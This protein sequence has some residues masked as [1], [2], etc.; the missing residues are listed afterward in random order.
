MRNTSLAWQSLDHTHTGQRCKSL[1]TDHS[2]P[3]LCLV[4]KHLL[5]FS[6]LQSFSSLHLLLFHW[7]SLSGAFVW[8]F[9]YTVQS[10]LEVKRCLQR[11]VCSSAGWA[12]TSSTG[13]NSQSVL[14]L[15]G[16]PGNL[17]VLTN[18]KEINCITLW[19]PAEMVHFGGFYTRNKNCYPQPAVGAPALP[20]L[21]PGF[22]QGTRAWSGWQRVASG[23]VPTA[24]PQHL[25][26]SFPSP[27]RWASNSSWCFGRKSLLDFF[28]VLE[29]TS[30]PDGR[31]L[32]QGS[33]S[34]SFS[35][36]S[37]VQAWHKVRES[38][39]W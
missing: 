17:S 1:P 24:G 31:C 35:P 26:S 10:L 23:T 7:Y 18:I 16:K 11:T 6:L 14:G 12:A 22:S 21:L 25:A 8:Y 32:V 28:L 30:A 34:A 15:C 19:F 2:W 39:S 4:K 9:L 33:L 37:G 36:P 5:L 38:P 27:P 20:A 3:P 29:A 13:V